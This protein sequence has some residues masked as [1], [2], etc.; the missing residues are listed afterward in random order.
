MCVYLASSGGALK[1]P[2]SSRWKRFNNVLGQK[3]EQI[4]SSV[5]G[6]DDKQLVRYD[7]IRYE[8]SAFL[9]H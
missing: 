1:K 2:V 4:V 6:D 7:T 5:R 9:A 8:K 3:E